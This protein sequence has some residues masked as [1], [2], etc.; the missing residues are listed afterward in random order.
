MNI[1]R[2]QL[3]AMTGAATTLAASIKLQ[4][5]EKASAATGL[6]DAYKDDF[7]IGAALSTSIIKKQ[8]PALV[9]LVN[10]EFNSITPENCM[11]WEEVRNGDGT[12]KWHDAD[13]FVEFGT[14]HQLHMVGHTLGWHSQIPES[15]FKN[16]AGNYIS[17]TELEKKQ[18][19]HISTI[20]ARY[21]G[22]LAAWDVVNEAV[23][24][25]NK[26][27]DSHWYKIMG[28]DFLVNAFNL[29]HEA[30]PKA[31][32]MYN[33]YNNERP[34]KRAATI[35]MLKRLQSRGTP[36]HGLGMQAHIG[37]DTNLQ[38]FE[39]SILAYSALGLKVH[40]TELDVDVLPS[41]WNLPV[42]EISTRFE[43]KP[44]RDPYTKGLP[45][46][47][48][49]KL[50][51]VYEGLFKILIKHRDKVDRVTLWGVSDDASWLNDFPIKG[52]TNYPL[53]FDRQHEPK[54]P[55]FRL[56]DLKR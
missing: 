35:D 12:W 16:S 6:K 46:K 21:K 41:V 55:Y 1:S 52:R 7:L 14:K 13:A 54:A 37:L 3:L 28:D 44:E 40:L 32:L 43:Y 22:K 30:D 18:K 48:E 23:G 29:A 8:D 49:D 17:K 31:H 51:K 20:V 53:L 26:M 39:D 19:E 2:R 11:K 15:V 38:D 4:A 45:K 50:A 25:D 9:A 34:E 24:D 10:K 42:A 36:I 27:R 5:A 47:V 33:D 56:L